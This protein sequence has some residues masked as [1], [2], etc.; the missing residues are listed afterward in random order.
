MEKKLNSSKDYFIYIKNLSFIGIFGVI[1]SILSASQDYSV[2]FIGGVVLLSL[3]FFKYDNLNFD[4][5]MILWS[6]LLAIPIT[7]FIRVILLKFTYS[8]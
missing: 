2:F 3:L 6:S 1:S 5:S 4:I 8:K 7:L